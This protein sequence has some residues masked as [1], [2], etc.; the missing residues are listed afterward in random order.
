MLYSCF[1]AKSGLYDYYADR[2][3]I[4]INAD[5]PVPSLPAPAGK[6]GVPAIDA[7]RPLPSD[8]KHIGRGWHAKGIVV[9]C[10]RGS[11]GALPSGGVVSAVRGLALIS[12][13]GLAGYYL[14]KRSEAGAVLGA[15]IGGYFAYKLE[16]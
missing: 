12:G 6:V 16:A 2:R 1:D 3:E 11:L 15:L 7:G 10:G 14:G 5:M 8:A 4:A 9:Q 13:I